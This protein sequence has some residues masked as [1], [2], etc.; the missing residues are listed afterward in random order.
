MKAVKNT[1]LS[2]TSLI[3]EKRRSERT[4]GKCCCYW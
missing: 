3:T 4:T 2:R 1:I